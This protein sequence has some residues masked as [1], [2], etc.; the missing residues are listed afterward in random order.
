[1]LGR[2]RERK[3]SHITSPSRLDTR[4]GAEAKDIMS[5]P[6][7]VL[8][9][10]SSSAR[11]SHSCEAAPTPPSL[12][13]PETAK[14]T[15]RQS[16]FTLVN[17]VLGA[18]VLGFPYVYK[19]C[20][21]GLAT[22]LIALVVAASALSMRLLLLAAGRARRGSYEALAAACLGPAGARCVDAC[23]L[24]MNLGGLVAYLNILAD[25]G[26]SVAGSVVPPGAEPS[27]DALLLAV[28]ALVALPVTLGVRRAAL[29][30]VVSQ[31]SVTFLFFFGAATAL[32][33]A[34][35]AAP[36]AEL[37]WWRPQGAPLAFPVVVY[38]FT[39]HQILFDI[40]ETLQSASVHSMT[41]VIHHSMALSTAMYVTVGAAGYIAYGPATAG[42]LLRNL[43]GDRASAPR[44]AFESALRIGFGLSILGTLPLVMLPLQA[45]CS[46]AWETVR[47]RA[48][49]CGPAPGVAHDPAR[50]RPADAAATA[51]CLAAACAL[52]VAVPNVEFVFGLAGSTASLVLAFVLPGAIFLRATAGGAE[53]S[54][55]AGSP[56]DDPGCV[57]GTPTWHA[58]GHPPASPP[59]RRGASV[60]GSA[61]QTAALRRR[62]RG[63]LALVVLG[64]LSA[65]LCTQALLRAVA[66]EARVARLARALV[67][68][69]QRAAAAAAAG[70]RAR[71]EAAHVSSVAAA[72]ALVR[73]AS[74]GA[75]GTL[76]SL[77]AAQRALDDAA[78]GSERARARAAAEGLAA[79]GSELDAA[80]GTLGGVASS[81]GR[82]AAL[83][84][85][86]ASAAELVPALL[87]G[88]EEAESSGG[89]GS[90]DQALSSALSLAGSW[91]HVRGQAADVLPW[92]R[93][94][95]PG[96]PFSVTG[97]VAKATG[98]A[99]K[100]TG[101]A[102][103]ATDAGTVARH[104]H[105]AAQGEGTAAA[106][107]DMN[108]KTTAADSTP[109]HQSNA[110][111][112][113]MSTAL[114]AQRVDGVRAEAAAA[115]ESAARELNGTAQA[116]L[117][118]RLAAEGAH[119]GARAARR[120]ADVAPGLAAAAA[121]LE[122]ACARVAAAA[123]SLAAMETR[124]SA[125]LAAAVA[126]LD[127]HRDRQE[128][129]AEGAALAGRAGRAGGGRGAAHDSP[130]ARDRRGQARADG[131][132]VGSPVPINATAVSEAA[133]KTAAEVVARARTSVETSIKDSHAEDAKRAIEIAKT[134][135][136]GGAATGEKGEGE[137]GHTSV[138]QHA[139]EHHGNTTAPVA[140]R[141]PSPST[142]EKMQG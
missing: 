108:P 110:G 123:A 111:D 52:A 86:N 1:M 56:P 21:L 32:T 37:L 57:A 104:E 131:A 15:P 71:T 74:R 76:R 44:R 89:S 72:A 82:S 122:A 40:Y 135:A 11:S 115:L 98:V 42:D 60:A 100:T 22:A 45:V 142:P 113:A 14:A 43:G 8:Q 24:I 78:G 69:D 88:R 29:L 66:Q 133:A 94:A 18:G 119:A 140:K 65:L 79:A 80:L 106:A 13:G 121:A 75:E 130:R 64:S 77:R 84:R 31:V 63:A 59:Q 49:A 114:S 137:H 109:A 26:S 25:T 30:A 124:R 58:P 9:R 118:A 105:T 35:P 95:V 41:R 54:T 127:G 3:S 27:R 51:A 70:A 55:V 101:G 132:L 99:A 102:G 33:A 39:A 67:R 12:Q 38:G 6:R 36:L 28:T 61:A 4:A 10:T 91:V 5:P 20:G 23:V 139:A 97:A 68:E 83:L 134:I 48:G 116:L 125:A 126:E 96:S 128:A 141:V 107:T 103:K 112:D 85:S 136:E 81:L 7:G 117:A 90:G 92:H 19:S 129:D 93:D 87:Q 50:L 73:G 53:A 47:R 138:I 17:A 62:R 16:V 46:R 34:A 2:P 120:A